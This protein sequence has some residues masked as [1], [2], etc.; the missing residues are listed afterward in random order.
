MSANKLPITFF[1]FAM[2]ELSVTLKV[3]AR[4]E[5]PPIA[6]VML[7]GVNLMNTAYGN[8]LFFNTI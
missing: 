6:N 8:I 5:T 2:A 7:A 3:S 4:N 1:R